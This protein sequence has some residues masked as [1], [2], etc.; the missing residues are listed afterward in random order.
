MW[1]PYTAQHLR[2][3]LGLDID[4]LHTGQLQYTTQHNFHLLVIHQ[5][6]YLKLL[7]L[8]AHD[9]VH[10]LH[11]SSAFQ[12]AAGHTNVIHAATYSAAWPIG[13]LAGQNCAVVSQGYCTTKLL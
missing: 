4:V 6:Q 5:T 1:Q 9:L 12:H 8:L 7:Q 3:V 13:E 2:L 10:L 11:F